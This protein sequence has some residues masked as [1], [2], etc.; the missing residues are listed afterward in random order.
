MVA[1]VIPERDLG[2]RKG[3]RRAP[4][5]C[6]ASTRCAYDQRHQ[7]LVL[8]MRRG[9]RLR[10]RL[11]P[12]APRYESAILIS[13]EVGSL[14]DEKT[15]F[16]VNGTG[17]FLIAGPQ[18]DTGMTGRKI[19]VDTYGGWVPHGGGAFSGKDPT[20]VDRSAAY[21]TDVGLASSRTRAAGRVSRIRPCE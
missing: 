18:A 6:S 16:T 5:G 17:K 15:K 3:S 14:V 4:C 10:Q 8:R 20:K 19:I 9:W 2:A 11:N 13:F 1:E 7:P 12:T 21:T